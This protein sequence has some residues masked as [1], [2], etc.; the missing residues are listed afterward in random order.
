MV[1]NLSQQIPGPL[2]EEMERGRSQ[3]DAEKKKAQKKA[4]KEKQKVNQRFFCSSQTRPRMSGSSKARESWS[5]VCRHLGQWN[6]KGI[7]Q[8]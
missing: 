7:C 6:R 2:T 3:K 5:F 4:K 8:K 1:T